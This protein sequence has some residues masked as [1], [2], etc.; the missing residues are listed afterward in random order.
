MI[1]VLFI[2]TFVDKGISQSAIC[3]FVVRGW[4][5]LFTVLRKLGWFF[6]AHRWRYGVALGLLLL[7]NFVE[8]VPPDLVGNAID[9]MNQGTMTTHY[10]VQLVA[11]LIGITVISYVFG[12]TWMYQ[13]F[14]G[15]N[16]LQRT[17]RARLM[18]HFLR[19]TPTFFERNRTGDLMARATNDLN[20]VS[21]TAGFGI[22]T[23][24]DSTTFSATILVTMGML[25][26]WKLTL[27]SLIPLPVMAYAMTKYGRILHDRFTLA[28]DAFGDMNDGV[29]ETI[30]GIRVVRAY[31]QE[32]R[33]EAK[34]EQTI[35][36]VYQKN[37]AVARIDALFDPTI[38]ILIGITYLIGLGYGTYL[39]FQSQLTIGQLTSFNVYLGMLIWP[40]LA[41]GQLIN[42]MQRGNASLDRVNETLRYQPDVHD[43]GED[44]VEV[45]IPDVIV[46]D[47]LSFRYPSSDTDIL[48]HIDLTIRRGQTIGIVGRTG[49]GKSTLIRQ[50]LREYPPAYAGSLKIAG[51]PIEQLRLS[52][53]HS[54]LGYVPQESM[55]FS[56]TVAEN[57]RFAAP[58]ATDEE[59]RRALEMADFWKDV[60]ALPSGLDTL[61]GEKGVSLSGG[62][63]QRIALARALITKPEILLLDDAMSAV[64]ARTE[65]H[66]LAAIRRERKGHTTLIATHRMSAVA[67]ADWIVVLDD[68]EI[69]EA[70]TH[71]DLMRRG[72]WYCEQYRRQQA[73]TGLDTAAE[74]TEENWANDGERHAPAVSVA[75]ERSGVE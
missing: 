12:F 57:V 46:F 74:V 42:I 20:A 67:H 15:A 53:L 49:S 37:I 38:N 6:W 22:L 55:L 66:I 56:R 21:Q 30:S 19:M 13:L 51:V 39:V 14:G 10:L 1:C 59:V 48:R 23:L 70:G 47:D 9:H 35:E 40:M 58:D 68:G 41:F 11:V 54:W 32:R 63:K 62:Q 44:G 36:D 52:H 64:D 3:L 24:I 33:Q 17:L 29:L 2:Q 27:L 28:Q 71:R 73:E 65:A 16:M 25:I 5:S 75:V 8:I 7:L 34:F 69:V 18:R 72:G 45:A 43:V 61:V 50:L 60:A 4:Q 31:A 26:S